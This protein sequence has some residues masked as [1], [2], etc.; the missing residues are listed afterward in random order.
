MPQGYI[1]SFVTS[2]LWGEDVAGLRELITFL[3]KLEDDNIFIKVRNEAN[4]VEVAIPGQR[5]E[6]EFLEDGTVDVDQ[7][8]RLLRC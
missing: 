2:L 5:W 1:I 7:R 4:M 3:N 8:W 6:I